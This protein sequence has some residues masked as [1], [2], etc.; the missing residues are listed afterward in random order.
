MT[1]VTIPARGSW[2]GTIRKGETLRIVDLEGQQ[3][4]DFICFNAHDTSEAYDAT[5]TV[6]LASRAYLQKGDVLYSGLARPM[7][8]IQ[9]DTVGYHD[10]IC[11]CCSA[12]IND[13]RYG[14]KN[15]PSCRANFLHELGKHGLDVRSVVPN[16]NFFMYI[17]F[18]DRGA[19]SFQPPLSKAGDHV[20]LL[21]HMDILVVLSNCPQ[22]LNPANNFNPT[23]IRIKVSEP[24]KPVAA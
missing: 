8:T 20:D 9:E 4:V 1:D 3:A 17:P 21:A 19:F 6:R 18:H 5:V 14:V 24:G 13:L 23:P 12:E 15:T 10:T 22:I 16:I 2:S 11:G 7:F